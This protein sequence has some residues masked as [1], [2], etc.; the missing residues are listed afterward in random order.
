MQKRSWLDIERR[1]SWI[2]ESMSA[3]E[4]IP[5]EI[6]S[7]VHILMDQCERNTH[8]DAARD[9]TVIETDIQ[10]IVENVRHDIVLMLT[11][12]PSFMGLVDKYLQEHINTS[13]D[14]TESSL[15]SGFIALSDVLSIDLHDIEQHLESAAGSTLDTLHDVLDISSMTVGKIIDGVQSA[16]HTFI[17]VTVST[18]GSI[19]NTISQTIH[20]IIE[21]I[22][23]AFDPLV[24][25]TVSLRDY[26]T[27]V[28]QRGLI[29]TADQYL[30]FAEEIAAATAE[31]VK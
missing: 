7:R 28:L 13:I 23:Q 22:E 5:W 18:L 14:D 16:L 24:L 29:F 9:L 26:I 25:A 31:R 10:V 2:N 15:E 20:S 8:K 19:Y 27:D 30:D 1:L 17:D 4:D 3:L 12:S 21:T 11:D 6:R